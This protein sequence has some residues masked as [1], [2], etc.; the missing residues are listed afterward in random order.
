VPEGYYRTG[1]AAKQLGVSS[2]HVRR[3][4]EAGEIAAELSDGQQWKIPA[5]EIARQERRGA[6]GAAGDRGAGRRTAAGL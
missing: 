5:A 3:L 6:A 1:Q 2:Y 4:C